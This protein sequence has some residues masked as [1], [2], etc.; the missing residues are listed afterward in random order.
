MRTAPQLDCTAFPPGALCADTPPLLAN[1]W[2]SDLPDRCLSRQLACIRTQLNN[3]RHCSLVSQRLQLDPGCIY[4]IGG[5]VDR[6]RHKQLCF[7]KAE[8]QVR[9]RNWF[10]AGLNSQYSVSATCIPTASQRLLPVMLA[11]A[12]V[13]FTF[14]ST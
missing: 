4:I 14:H 11:H 8:E 9:L 1:T 6:N 13:H 12:L 10:V 3:G 2:H 5:I 7:N